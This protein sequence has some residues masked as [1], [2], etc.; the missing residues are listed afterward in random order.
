G[1][2]GMMLQ[3][4]VK[5]PNYSASENPD[6]RAS[7]FL[8]GQVNQSSQGGPV[9]LAYGRCRIGSTVVSAGLSAERI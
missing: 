7:F 1:G 4:S 3:P 6:Q 2:I 9:V 8:G 5:N